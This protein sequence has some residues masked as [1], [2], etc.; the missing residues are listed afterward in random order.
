MPEPVGTTREGHS[1][2]L[3]VSRA[4]QRRIVA[5]FRQ[6]RTGGAVSQRQ[7]AGVTGIPRTTLQ[8]WIGRAVPAGVDAEISAFF[9]TPAGVVLLRRILVAA[10][11]SLCW[12][13]AGGTRLVC[14][15]VVAAGLGPF[16]ANSYGAQHG[17]AAQIQAALVGFGAA[18]GERLRVGM[19]AREITVCE[20]ETFL[21]QGICLVAVEPVSGFVLLEDFAER[22]DTETWKGALEAAT[23]GMSVKVVQV[24]SDEAKAL[25]CH[26]ETIDAHHSPDLFH[27]QHEVCQA[28]SLPL[29]QRRE[30]AHEDV[31][32]AAKAV[33]RQTQERAAYW[34]GPRGPGRP[35][36]FSA[37]ARATEEALAGA[38][39][40]AETAAKHWEDW[41]SH[42]H[43]IGD[44][45][46][47]YD[48]ESGARQSP[49]AVAAKLD[50]AFN[51]L[52]AIVREAGLS[53]RSA[54]GVE[55]AA[56]VAPKMVATVTFFEARVQR[57]LEQLGL[58]LAEEAL[59]R[60]VILPA[61]YLERAAARRRPVQ[62][63]IIE[64]TARRLRSTVPTPKSTDAQAALQRAAACLADEFQRSSSCVEG[65]N[66]RLSQYQHALRQ[67]NPA[68]Q[69]ALT[70]IHNYVSKRPDGT[71]A[72]ER[73]FGA[74]PNDLI[75]YL[76][77]HITGPAR[78]A[79]SRA[80][81][82]NVRH[83]QASE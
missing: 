10:H 14:A 39:K 58:P 25:I 63:R 3:R 67:L 6:G 19:P 44:V 23:A 4:R 42:M 56:R 12:M 57:H 43:A 78:P 64:A 32:K 50:A 83:V 77:Q 53:E 47:P 74:V 59:L 21:A 73:F 46:H 20:D 60:E 69:A 45:Y 29:H 37:R 38:K 61:T 80:R 81:A 34:A 27:V 62:R 9:E 31:A 54:A 70:V 66:G 22:R 68:K 2:N 76:L 82:S 16:I 18:E 79:A 11:V 5:E 49:A 24:T 26:A 40:R 33:E 30:H 7:H 48:L 1:R 35:P 71:T 55:K 36:D 13:G 72:A 8:H 41:R 17:V 28:V 65:R 75:D 51:G 15:F 52:R